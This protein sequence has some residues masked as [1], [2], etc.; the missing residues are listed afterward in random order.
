MFDWITRWSL[1]NRLLTAVAYIILLVLGIFVVRRMTLDVF[2]EFA[3]PQVVIQT[4]APGLS[5]ED[6]EILITFPIEAVVNG[7][8]GVDVVRS[9]SSAG[10][11]IVIAVFEWGTDIYTARQLVN[12]RL[13]EV[14]EQFPPGTEAPFMQPIT[15]AVGWLVKFALQSETASLLDLRTLCDWEIRNRILAGAYY[16][17]FR[18]ITGFDFPPAGFD[19]LMMRRQVVDAVLG[20]PLYRLFT[21]S[22]QQYGLAELIRHEPWPGFVVHEFLAGPLAARQGFKRFIDRSL[23]SYSLGSL[24]WANNFGE[25]VADADQLVVR[26]FDTSGTARITHR[27]GSTSP[28]VEARGEIWKAVHPDAGEVP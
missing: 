11:S 12:E 27:V 10:L 19:F 7:T 16:R 13:Q 23:N 4:Q 2:P 5:P 14:R 26:I 15:S 9:K 21:L 20:Y 28:V 22:F 6:V 1:H 3:P 18:R 25:I 8:P 17:L 24:G